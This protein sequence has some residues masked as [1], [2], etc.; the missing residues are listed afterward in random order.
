MM[1]TSGKEEKEALEVVVTLGAAAVPARGAAARGDMATPRATA[2]ESTGDTRREAP[3]ELVALA[4]RRT[5]ARAP[6][7][8]P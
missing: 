8:L 5:A 7:S 6:R 2:T 4:P 3:T 1:L